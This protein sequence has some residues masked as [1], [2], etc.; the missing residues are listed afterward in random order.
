MYVLSADLTS[1]KTETDQDKMSSLITEILELKI[2]N[3]MLKNS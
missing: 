3:G 2:E 1:T